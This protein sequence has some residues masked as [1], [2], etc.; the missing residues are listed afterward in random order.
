MQVNAPSELVAVIVTTKPSPAGMPPITADR[1]GLSER[2]TCPSFV[3]PL[4][5]VRA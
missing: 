4:P 2:A 3:N 5:R 1:C